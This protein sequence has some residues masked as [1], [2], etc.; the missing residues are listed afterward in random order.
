MM[1]IKKYG[2][3]ADLNKSVSIA[4]MYISSLPV[5]YATVPATQASNNDWIP[6]ALTH[7]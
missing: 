3:T 5:E 6:K 1:Y 4:I 2:I 7:E